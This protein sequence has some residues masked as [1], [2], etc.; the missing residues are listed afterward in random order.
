LDPQVH[1]NPKA[2]RKPLTT[3]NW[4]VVP[5]LWALRAQKTGNVIKGQNTYQHF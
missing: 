5:K 1:V 3:G 4:D 2:K